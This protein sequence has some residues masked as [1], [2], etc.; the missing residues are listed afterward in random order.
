MHRP[1]C[2]A[3]SRG[4]CAAC[5]SPALQVRKGAPGVENR[6]P[7]VRACGA[8]AHPL[9]LLR[10]GAAPQQWGAPMVWACADTAP[11]APDRP[12]A[13]TT[14]KAHALRAAAAWARARPPCSAP[15]PASA[16]GQHCPSLMSSST[17]SPLHTHGGSARAAQASGVRQERR[18]TVLRGAHAQVIKAGRPRQPATLAAAKDGTEEAHACW[19]DPNRQL[20]GLSCDV[21]LAGC[22]MHNKGTIGLGELGCR[23]SL[24]WELAMQWRAHAHQMLLPPSSHTLHTDQRK[25]AHP[26]QHASPNDQCLTQPSSYIAIRP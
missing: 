15:S 26:E 10:P 3:A 12:G 1:A 7:G 25:A 13:R 5:G 18:H 17:P 11:D 20:A 14:G 16:S 6:R 24:P 8:G 9:A 19:L 4:R 21:A 23:E 2:Q 22:S